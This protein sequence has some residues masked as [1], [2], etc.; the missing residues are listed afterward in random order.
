M[1]NLVRRI[2]LVVDSG[3]AGEDTFKYAVS[4]AERFDADL[5][6]RRATHQVVDFTIGHQGEASEHTPPGAYQIRLDDLVARRLPSHIRL[7]TGPIVSS[8]GD[9]IET[10]VLEHDINVVLFGITDG[11]GRSVC[12]LGGNSMEIVHLAAN[13]GCPQECLA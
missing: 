5:H 6:I 9:T 10:Y 13:F 1:H 12:L 8:P 3:A 2:L 4:M 7:V 11:T